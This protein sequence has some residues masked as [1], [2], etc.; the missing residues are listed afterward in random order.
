MIRPKIVAGDVPDFI[1][2]D[3]GEQSGVVNSMI[4]E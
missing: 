4:K 2:L 1:Y 3:L